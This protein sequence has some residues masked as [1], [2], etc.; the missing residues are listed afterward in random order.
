MA[1]TLSSTRAD[2]RVD[3]RAAPTAAKDRFIGVDAALARLAHQATSDTPDAR[4]CGPASDRSADA[5]IAQ[6]FV[7]AP[8]GPADLSARIP[9]EQQSLGKR[10]TLARV[11]IV[12]C[13]GAFAIWAWRSYGGPARDMIAA[14]AP[15]LAWISARSADQTPA[16][17]MPDPT[18]E[19]TAAPP[20]L[21]TAAPAPA[22]TAWQP[23]SIAQPATT[24]ANERA[25]ASADRQQIE[26]MARDLAVL[27]QTVERLAAGQAQLTREIA[28]LQGA[29][30]QA[31]KAPAEKPHKRILG[32][33]SGPGH[34][35]VFDPAQNPNAPGVPH[36]LGS[37]VLPRG[38]PRRR[39]GPT[40]QRRRRRR[41]PLLSSRR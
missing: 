38:S 20:A 3:D 6:S 5:N 9:R 19:Q 30:L 39:A 4:P 2:P 18:P 17:R 16:P 29:K 7:A 1:S 24:P 21:A 27:R 23:A 11:A 22:R 25:A 34:S 31:D 32:R 41:K 36:T 26:T 8:L 13:L 33:V 28:K 12:V 37:I 14:W 35:D 40:R 15:P 10:G